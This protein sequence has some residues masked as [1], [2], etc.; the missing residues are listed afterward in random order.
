MGPIVRQSNV[1]EDMLLGPG[2]CGKPSPI[3]AAGDIQNG[4]CGYGPRLPL[5]VISPHARRNYVDHAL[6]DQSSILRFIEDNWS[7][8]R[9]G[10]GSADATAGTLNGLFDFDG[11]GKAGRLF[12]DPTTG[13]IL[14]RDRDDD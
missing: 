8:G 4:R 6:T 3:D 5:L 13:R 9:I 10:N 1:A 12:L 2:N 11:H 14:S 7:L